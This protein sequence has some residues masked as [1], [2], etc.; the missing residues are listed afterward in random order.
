M[1]V[2]VV[3]ALGILL[4]AL[5]LTLK[6]VLAPAAMLVAV[7]LVVVAIGLVSSPPPAPVAPV[8]NPYGEQRVGWN[9]D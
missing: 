1:I 8:L 2:Y 9:H 6:N 3:V 7:A 4:V 5:V